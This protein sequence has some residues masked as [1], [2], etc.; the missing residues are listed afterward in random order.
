MADFFRAI[1]N[2]KAYNFHK[3]SIEVAIY[4]LNLDFQVE[5][6]RTRMKHLRRKQLEENKLIVYLEWDIESP[7]DVQSVLL[8]FSGIT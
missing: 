8:H 3:Y 5:S 2:M 1:S 7:L 6:A 4:N